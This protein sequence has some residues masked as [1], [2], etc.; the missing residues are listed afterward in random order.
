MENGPFEDVFPIKKVKKRFYVSYSGTVSSGAT[1]SFS[2]WQ[3]PWPKLRKSGM[4]IF[5][6]ATTTKNMLQM[7]AQTCMCCMRWPPGIPFMV[8]TQQEE[9]MLGCLVSSWIETAG[10]KPGK[11]D[12]EWVTVAVPCVR[13]G[14]CQLTTII[15]PWQL[16]KKRNHRLN[17]Q[18]LPSCRTSKPFKFPRMP[19]NLHVCYSSARTSWG[20]ERAGCLPGFV[21][22]RLAGYPVDSADIRGR[23][24]ALVTKVCLLSEI[25]SFVFV[26]NRYKSFL[27]IRTFVCKWDGRNDTFKSIISYREIFCLIFFRASYEEQI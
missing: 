23:W 22:E 18:P 26:Y 4:N 27:L 6:S 17:T 19:W 24:W 14:F 11:S 20:V 13:D 3:M 21:S 25:F 1:G 9:C 7:C 8:R 16:P 12:P 10:E 15:W 2:V 5:F